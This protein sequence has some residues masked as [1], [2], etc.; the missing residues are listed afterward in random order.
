M[1]R[2][3]RRPQGIEHIAPAVFAAGKLLGTGKNPL[4]PLRVRR[5]CGWIFRQQLWDRFTLPGA[6]PQAGV[7]GIAKQLAAEMQ[8]LFRL[9]QG[10]LQPADLGFEL[11]AALAAVFQL[12]AH[13][14]LGALEAFALVHTPY[15]V[16]HRR[17][18]GGVDALGQQFV[19]LAH[20][21]RWQGSQRQADLLGLPH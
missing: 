9:L 3:T 5:R 21:H 4:G 8:P 12:Q 20:H 6:D 13:Q 7:E 11:F 10:L 1:A 19:Q 16:D 14:R 15:L 2:L 17:D 18:G